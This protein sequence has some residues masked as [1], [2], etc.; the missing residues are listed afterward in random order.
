[1]R[2]TILAR[3][4]AKA[5][6]SL[7]KE[8]DK[9]DEYREALA[10]IADLYGELP[11]L[12]ESLV[13]PLF[14]LEARQKVMAKIAESVGAD[15]ILTRFLDLLVEKETGRVRYILAE[16]GGLLS[17]K[18]RMVVIPDCILTRAGSGQA[19]ASATLEYIQDSPLI[20]DPDNITR[21]EEEAL[22]SHY[23]YKP[24][25]E[26]VGALPDE[27]TEEEKQEDESGRTDD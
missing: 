27:D 12:V 23:G 19:V 24:Y 3:R 26:Q 18:G 8:Q 2:Q 1:V 9:V 25:W 5:L 11:E 10:A 21:E 17:I 22:Y 4:Y 13:N 15:A 7:G 16:I 6:F 20:D 14:P